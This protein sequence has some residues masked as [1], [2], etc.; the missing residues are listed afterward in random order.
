MARTQDRFAGAKVIDL[1][2]YDRRTKAPSRR[3]PRRRNAVTLTLRVDLVDAVPPTWRQVEVPSTLRLDQV[4]DLLQALFGWTDSHLHRFSLG[5]G[6]WDDGAELFLCPYDVEEGEDDGVPASEVRLDEVLAEVGDRLDYVYDYGDS[7]ELTLLV[8]ALAE[9]V[10]GPR[11]LAGGG[12]S[13]PD[14]SG[15]VHAWNEERADLPVDLSRLQAAVEAAASAWSL[16]API[17]QL[18]RRLAHAPSYRLVS[19]LLDASGLGTL[20]AADDAA[21]AGPALRPYQWL[22]DRVGDG[23]ALTQAGYLP[24]KH[25]LACMTELEL[26]ERWIGKGNREDLTAPVADLRRSAR[27]LGLLRVSKGRLLPTNAGTAARTDSVLLAE[28]VAAK[29]GGLRRERAQR[30]LT[31][32]LLLAV[33]AGRSVSEVEVLGGLAK[34]MGDLG[35]SRGDGRPLEPWA[36]RRADADTHELL[37]V[38][39]C[40]G[41]RPRVA[42]GADALA[43]LTLRALR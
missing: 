24:P 11:V 26:D 35:W 32:L 4:H 16:P 43:R 28:T 31:A 23:L 38:L 15:G 17:V 25:V 13:P 3:R 37:G 2:A 1:A 29:A 30:E 22:L 10:R 36:L 39:G 9:G 7:W 34:A 19:E 18:L 21:L 8:E 6:P 20:P 27:R 5:G 41:R 33:A 42:P 40:A 12:G 14:D